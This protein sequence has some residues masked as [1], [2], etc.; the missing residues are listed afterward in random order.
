MS[1]Y[2]AAYRGN[3]ARAH[4]GLSTPSPRPLPQLRV[5]RGLPRIPVPANINTP[6]FPL[7][8]VFPRLLP[9][10]LGPIGVALTAYEI[11][12]AVRESTGHPDLSQYTQ[13]CSVA[14]TGP[15]PQFWVNFGNPTCGGMTSHN[16]PSTSTVTTW[17]KNAAPGN[18]AFIWLQ[19]FHSNNP[20]APLFERWID[21]QRWEHTGSRPGPWFRMGYFSP[22][23]YQARTPEELPI[24]NPAPTPMYRGFASP[25]PGQMP[26]QQP[27]TR[28]N[29]RRD[30]ARGPVVNLPPMPYPI[31]L[32]PPY[33]SPG[34][35]I[36]PVPLQPPTI[37][38][39]PGTGNNPGVSVTPTP[40]PPSN[41]PPKQGTK[42]RKLNI[43]TVAGRLWAVIGGMTEGLDFFYVLWN[44]IPPD[45]RSSRKAHITEHFW[46]LYENW[47][48]IDIGTAVSNYLNNQLE[49]MFYGAIGKGEAKASQTIGVTTGLGRAT[50]S[51]AEMEGSPLP[52]LTYDESTGK[53]GL[54]WAVFGN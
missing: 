5:P 8:K 29:P 53:W 47:D 3:A 35:G 45:K 38:V 9:R 36:E 30:P 12:Q 31:V 2:P 20:A 10:V 32:V 34:P 42:E 22:S 46:D 44:S 1:R 49:D 28:T 23:P 11:Y 7:E 40:S 21:V 26:S 33:I 13:L 48:E 6:L 24:H 4:A 14:P 37:V 16:S 41:S 18:Y 19:R 25:R 27:S 15:G 17:T 52:Q 54:D 39:T 50:R 43:R 51:P